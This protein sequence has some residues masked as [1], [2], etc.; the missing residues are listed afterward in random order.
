MIIK[1]I[2]VQNF[3][4]LKDVTLNCDP[5][6]VLVGQNGTGK[7]CLLQALKIFYEPNANYD[8]SDFF[9]NNTD[10][11]ISITVTFTKLTKHERELFSP[12]I[13]GDNLIIEKVLKYPPG[14]RSQKYFGWRLKNPDFEAFRQAKGR[15]GLSQAYNELRQNKK[16]RSFPSYTNRDEIEAKL[17]GW[18]ASHPDQ[19]ERSRDEG[20]FFGFKEVGESRLE[21]HTR[22]IPVPAVQDAAEEAI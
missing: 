4:C 13:S 8:E 11:D 14:R 3:R 5:L 15:S 20:Q 10:D 9:A 2:I 1:S 19:C 18:E 12:Y 7:S 6:T 16:Y 22:F 21:R 17:T